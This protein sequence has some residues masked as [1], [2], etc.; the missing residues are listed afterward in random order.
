MPIRGYCLRCGEAVVNHRTCP[1]ILRYL[2]PHKFQPVRTKKFVLG[3]MG[4]CHRCNVTGF[5]WDT[6]RRRV[7]IEDILM[8]RGALKF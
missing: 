7:V 5:Q 3:V 2:D 1:G 8:Q 4:V 6:Y